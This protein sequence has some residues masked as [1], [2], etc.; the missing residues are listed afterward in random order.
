[1][2]KNKIIEVKTDYLIIGTGIAGLYTALNLCKTGEVTLITK[3][4]IK[5][6]NTQYAQG[7]IAAVL[8]EEDS[9]ELHINDTLKA[10]AG[11]C[12]KE[13]VK[14][15]VTEGPE[16]VKELIELGTDFDNIEGEYDLT[17]EGAHSKR[18]I[19]HARGDATGEEIRE[20]LT[21][22]AR[23]KE[24][25]KI[26]EKHYM[27]DFITDDKTSGVKAILVYDE[28]KHLYK[29]YHCKNVILASGGCGQVY[30]NT[31]NPDITTGDGVAA[32]YRAGAEIMDMEFVQFH[33]TTLYNPGSSPFLISE[34]LRGEGAV[35]RNS[36]NKRF[37]LKYHELAD[38]APRDVVARSIIKEIESGDN[39]Y[40][41]LDITKREDNYLR[42]RFPSIYNKVKKELGINMGEEY[43]P[44]VPAAHYMMGGVKTD[45]NGKTSI[46]GLYA[47]GEVACTGVHGA[48][49]LA[50]NS[51][52]EGLVFGYRIYKYVSKRKPQVVKKSI[53]KI[54]QE[55]SFT[56]L[57][58]EEN[59]DIEN[60]TDNLRKIM[61]KKAGIIREKK[62][63]KEIVSWISEKIGEIKKYKGTNT[64]YWEL[65]NM[66][67]V[68]HFITR[69]ALKREE[70][71]GGHYRKDFPEPD[72]E[73]SKNHIIFDNQDVEG[74]INVLE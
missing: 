42:K 38:L 22:V 31:S 9:L 69:A 45:I 36:A 13:A 23:K 61:M 3:D 50:S 29:I 1:M 63:L 32:A 14:I 12:N 70:S 21:D 34:S 44:V 2:D 27:V 6:S 72:P 24:N 66:L 59:K 68:A 28:R 62:R 4:K 57:S 7:G 11:L 53:N 67:T 58:Q 54:E 65:K 37:M 41:W 25:I 26:N 5:E 49:R 40:V 55:I 47:C 16:R 73:W 30:K 64:S 56:R 52:L 35:L 48:N 10:G 71:R 74:K 8:A 39:P 15:L 20:S 33:P 60:I 18:R 19:L 46:K 51:L 43:I 17:R